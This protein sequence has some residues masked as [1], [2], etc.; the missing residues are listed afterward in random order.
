VLNIIAR[1]IAPAQPA[2]AAQLQGAAH[3][4]ALGIRAREPVPLPTTTPEVT[5]GPRR[6]V[7]AGADLFTDVRRATSALLRDAL[8][9]ALLG[10]LRA[11]GA[12]MDKERI[13]ELTLDRIAEASRVAA[14]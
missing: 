10:E 9:D 2:A 7:A 6:D 12:A 4:M 8:G 3:R 14:A 1:V 11:E 13:V 5:A